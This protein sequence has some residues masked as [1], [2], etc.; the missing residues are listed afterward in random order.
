MIVLFWN[1]ILLLH[2]GNESMVTLNYLVAVELLP[3][4]AV[5]VF[6]TGRVE[7]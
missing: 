1:V 6:K 7:L 4:S 3:D 2:I 5:L